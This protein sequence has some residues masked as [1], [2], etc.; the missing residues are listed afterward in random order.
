MTVDLPVPLASALSAG[1]S[2]TLLEMGSWLVFDLLKPNLWA[3]PPF[4]IPWLDDM[5]TGLSVDAQRRNDQVDEEEKELERRRGA[6]D[7]H[8][9]SHDGNTA[10]LAVQRADPAIPAAV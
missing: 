9:S 1:T 3:I 10:T 2:V 8:I 7:I 5:V 4:V 6:T